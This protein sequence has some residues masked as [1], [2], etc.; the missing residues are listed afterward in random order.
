MTTFA[1]ILK[2]EVIAVFSCAQDENYW[3]NVKEIADD[4]PRLLAYFATSGMKNPVGG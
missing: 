3:P 1:Q 4:D 2:D